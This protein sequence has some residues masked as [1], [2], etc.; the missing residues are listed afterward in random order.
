MSGEVNKTKRVETLINKVNSL[1]TKK[2]DDSIQ[3]ELS[4]LMNLLPEIESSTIPNL[5]GAVEVAISAL[6]L[7]NPNIILATEIRKDIDKRVGKHRYLIVRIIYGSGQPSTK[8]IL[9]LGTLLIII[10]FLIFLL[11]Y[12]FGNVD[13]FG[14]DSSMLLMVGTFGALGGIVSI[15][16]RIQDFTNLTYVHPSVLFFTGFFKP[17]VGM[18]FAVFVFAILEAGVIP[19]VIESE[20][21]TFFYM[22]LSFVSG[23]SERF[24]KDIITKTEQTIV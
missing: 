19:V 3:K 21:E 10:P 22:A 18:S 23:F 12:I 2:V 7:D 17:I 15:M 4:I 13:I 20:K 11:I 6:L 9:G 1:Q 14:I 24:A 16:A 5:I 8:V